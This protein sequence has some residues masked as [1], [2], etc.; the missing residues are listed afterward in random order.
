MSPALPNQ[1]QTDLKV[2]MV[3]E[4]D[5]EKGGCKFDYF[6]STTPQELIDDGIYRSASKLNKT[7]FLLLN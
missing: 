7:S 5:K 1:I 4:N 6:F 3:H 2:I